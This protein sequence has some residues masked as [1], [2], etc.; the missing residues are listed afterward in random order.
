MTAQLHHAARL[1]DS[2]GQTE[3]AE[4]VRL[5]AT[6]M[7]KTKPCQDC[8]TLIPADRCHKRCAPCAA[9]AVHVYQAN[10][11]RKARKTNAAYKARRG[12]A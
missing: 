5:A 10:Y 1:L 4:T 11:D 3:L 6:L 2:L 12:V 8:P 9:K 7:P